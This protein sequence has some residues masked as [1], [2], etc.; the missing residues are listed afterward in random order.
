MRKNH[1]E[2]LE[3]V[4]QKNRQG[5]GEQPLPDGPL[6]HRRLRAMGLAHVQSITLPC[7]NF[8]PFWAVL[9]TI[10]L[11]PL[12]SKR[13]F[14]KPSPK[15]SAASAPAEGGVHTGSRLQQAPAGGAGRN[16][17]KNLRGP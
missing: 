9:H 17:R 16:R 14:P 1:V 2:L 12:D 11:L 6:D 13:V 10:L 3:Q 8:R 5:K 7:H 15:S 4:A